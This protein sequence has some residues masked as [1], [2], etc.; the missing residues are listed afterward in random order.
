MIIGKSGNSILATALKQ[1]HSE[2]IEG[3]VYL[4]PIGGWGHS[5]GTLIGMTNLQRG[6]PVLGDLPLLGESYYSVELYAEHFVPERNET[7]KFYLEEDV[8]WEMG[9]RGRGSG[10]G[11]GRRSFMLLDLMERKAGMG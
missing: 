8:Y 1:M 7:L 9:R 4:H 6:V 5:A 2:G 10:C 11:G 3:S